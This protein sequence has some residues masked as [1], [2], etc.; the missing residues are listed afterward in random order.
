ML[1]TLTY[2][3]TG[4]GLPLVFI[5]GWGFNSAVWQPLKDQLSDHYQVITIDL[6]GFGSNINCHLDDY[7]LEN[8]SK[9]ITASINHPAIYIGWSLGGLVATHIALHYSSQVQGLITVASS[10]YFIEQINEDST[11]W[12][13]IKKQVLQ[14][15][16]Q[17]LQENIKNTLTNFLKIQAMG[18]ANTREDIKQLQRLLFKYPMPSQ[19]TLTHAL[20]LL[21]TTDLR[22]QL[23]NIKLPFLRLYGRLDSLVPQ[24]SIPLIDQ[25][26][27]QSEHYVFAKASHAPFISHRDEFISQLT[28]WLT[29]HF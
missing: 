9:L 16:Y 8:I 26:S 3:S 19:Y 4:Q 15:F 29:K 22:K 21:E 5:H 25:L 13:G 17:Q 1:P 2:Q 27:P 23:H 7:S 14:L 12:P 20:T 28:R 18:S 11:I 6:P 10:P 24:A